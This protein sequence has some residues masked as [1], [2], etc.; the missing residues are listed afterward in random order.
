MKTVAIKATVEVPWQTV[1]NILVNAFEGGSN[2]WYMIHDKKR[3]KNFDNSEKGDER[4]S[5]M[6][7][8]I[9]EGG[10]ILVSNEKLSGGKGCEDGEDDHKEKWVNQKSLTRGMKIMAE[11]YPEHF[12]DMISENDD[13]ITGDVLLQCTIFGKLIYG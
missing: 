8:P 1:G 5:H 3:P 13:S 10:A 7:Y 6:S 4:F 2:Y 12:N 11:K 9:N